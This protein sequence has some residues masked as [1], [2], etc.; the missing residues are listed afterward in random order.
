MRKAKAV[1][2]LD[3]P[4]IIERDG[5]QC[6]LCPHPYVLARADITFDHVVPISREGSHIYKNVRVACRPCNSRKNTYLLSELAA[7]GLLTDEGRF[8]A[9]A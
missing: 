3:L 6:Y 2:V 8:R 5:S 4:Y 1:E 9:P 7:H